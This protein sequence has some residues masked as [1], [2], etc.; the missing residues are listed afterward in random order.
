MSLNKKNSTAYKLYVNEQ[1]IKPFID[2]IPDYFNI[3]YDNGEEELIS[4]MC[5]YF[6]DKIC[7]KFDFYK[8]KENYLH[9]LKNLSP[10]KD[11]VQA[12]KLIEREQTKLETYGRIKYYLDKLDNHDCLS[13]DILVYL[14][15]I[16]VKL[17]KKSIKY[18]TESKMYKYL[19]LAYSYET[20]IDINNCVSHSLSQLSKDLQ[21]S[22]EN[23][24]YDNKS[25][26]IS[27]LDNSGNLIL[28]SLQGEEENKIP[29]T[30]EEIEEY[31]SIENEPYE[32][33]VF[34]G[35][36]LF[37]QELRQGML[38]LPNGMIF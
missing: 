20:H 16:Y 28:Y 31:I 32:K 4:A 23:L 1:F 22:V 2:Y 9:N 34:V 27:S 19:R 24:F 30:H 13:I 3:E 11:Y 37:K 25:Q 6:G 8:I 38:T 7:E 33:D 14:Y 29:L 5:W 21:E 10:N 15:L 35:E 18:I 12:H 36:L 26:Y 17:N